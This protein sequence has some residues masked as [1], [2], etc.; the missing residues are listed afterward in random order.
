MNFSKIQITWILLLLGCFIIPNSSFSQ[1]ETKEKKQIVIVKK[2]IGKDGNEVVEKI[3]KEGKEAEDFDVAKYLKEDELGATNVNVEVRVTKE[4][5]EKPTGE[6]REVEVTV[7]GDNIVIM[8]GDE[9]IVIKI[10]GD[11][12]KKE[13]ITEDGKHIIIMK[14]EDGDENTFEFLENIDVEMDGDKKTEI[15]IMK[16]RKGNGAFF[17]VMIDPTAEGMELL[18]VVKDSPAEKAGLKKGDILQSVN[19]HQISTYEELTKA[20]SNYKAGDSIVVMYRRDGQVNKVQ[21][22]LADS[23]DIPSNNKMIWKTDDGKVIEMKEGQEMHFEEEGTDGAKKI[24]KKII[25]KK[26]K[27][28]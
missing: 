14:S 9:K 25:I 6:E 23:K 1:T 12:T 15:R 4:G 22:N 24:K 8:E 26:E 7:T 21:A 16:N 18:D 3:V 20:L 17:G 28:N 11:E 10:D 5:K 13:I 19:E 27:N 2:T